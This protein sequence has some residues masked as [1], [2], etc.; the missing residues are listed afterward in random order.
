MISRGGTLV[1]AARRAMKGHQSA[2]PG[3]I[4]LT[5]DTTYLLRV[6]LM[7]IVAAQDACDRETPS[8]E[9]RPQG[10]RESHPRCYTQVRRSR[11][12][13]EARIKIQEILGPQEDG[14]VSAR[15]GRHEASRA[16]DKLS[17]TLRC[18]AGLPETSADALLKRIA[19][20][21]DLER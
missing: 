18:A 12:T 1:R 21:S 9:P 10:S 13:V 6:R 16:M 7:L 5:Q 17:P 20:R 8:A 2:G 19:S 3:T 11:E 14:V 4:R 15:R